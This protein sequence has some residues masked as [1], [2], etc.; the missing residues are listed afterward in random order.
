[1]RP[2]DLQSL[3][4]RSYEVNRASSIDAAKPEMQQQQFVKQF[5]KELRHETQFVKESGKTEKGLVDKDGKNKNQQNGK[6]KG[7]QG[8]KNE[9]AAEA[10]AAHKSMSMLDIKA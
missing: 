1:M 8:K 4:P 5:D 9:A 2:I 10:L 6:E 3:I 7:K